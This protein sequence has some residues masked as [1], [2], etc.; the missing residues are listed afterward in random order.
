MLNKEVTIYDLARQLHLSTATVSRALNND[1]V[2]SRKTRETIQDFAE[3]MGYQRNHFASH[4]RTSKTFMI[5][6]IVHALDSQFIT[7]AL[8]GIEEVATKEGYSP[9]IT[10]S[11][12]SYQREVS[13]ARNL[14]HRRVD[15]LIASLALDT[16]DL[17]HFDI[18]QDKGVPVVFF[19]RAEANSPYTQVVIDNYQCGYDATRHLI[20]QG[21]RNIMLVTGS[22]HC[23]AYAERHRGYAAA[24]ADRGIPYQPVLTNDL[25]EAGGIAA[26]MQILDMP[27]RPDGLFITNDFTAVVCMQTLR[28]HGIRIPQDIAVVGFNDDEVC[29]IV[30]PNLTTIRYPG[31][32]MGEVAALTLIQHLTGASNLSVMTKIVLR[33]ELVVRASSLRKQYLT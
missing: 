3:Q 33:S 10:H 11:R 9:I 26:A 13:N 18:Y 16:P 23:H 32:D 14:F 4:L 24:L 2:V 29:K 22:L 30:E 19:D 15:G 31:K 20:D 8:A 27:E 1:P 6:V 25:C 5:G 12:E 17:N 28:Q 21:C 7:S